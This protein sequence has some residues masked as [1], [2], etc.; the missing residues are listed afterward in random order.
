MRPRAVLLLVPLAA[1]ELLLERGQLL[2][3]GAVGQVVRAEH[4]VLGG[5]GER[6]AVRRREDVVRRQHQQPGLRLRLRGQR[7]V[8]GHLVAVEVR[9][10]RVTDERMHLDRLALHEHRLE[11]LQTEAVERRRTVEQHRVLL[12]DLLEHVPDLGDHRVDHLLGRLDVLHRLALDQPRHDERLEQLERHQLGQAALVEAQLRTGHDDR[13]AGVVHALAEQVLAEPALLALEHVRERL[14]RTVARARDGPAAAAVVEQRVDGLLQHALLVVDD[15]LGR[16]E[17]EQPLEPVVA[18]DHAAVEVVEVGRREATAVELHHRA[19]LRRDHRHGLQDHVLGLVVRV[20]EGR[21][22]LQA[23]DRTALLLA[24]GG[25]DLVLELLAL[26]LEVHL[27]EQVAHR[28]GAH[29]AA[30]VLAEPERRSEAVLELAEERLVGHHQ[31]GLHGLEQLPDL[32]HASD[33]VLDVG[34]GVGDVGLELLA[35]L[36]LHLLAL[37]VGQLLEVDVERVG[38]DQVVVVEALLVAGREVGDAALERLAQLQH[39]LLALGLVGVG[40]LLDLALELAQILLARLVV[41]PRHDRRGEVEDLL[42]LLG[43]HVEQ[44][45]DAARHA[46]EEPDVRDGRGQ[47]DVTHALAAHLRARDLDAAALADDALVADPLV[48]AAVALPVLGGTED[49]LAEEAVLLRLQRAVVDRLRLDDLA[50][51]PGSDLLRRREPDLDCVEII[52]VDHVIP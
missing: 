49:A 46:L 10:E 25:L 6:R 2:R 20:E 23:L 3:V 32:A 26:L 38:P 19:Q 44:V 51:A 7:H 52:D 37:V 43:S 5:H 21:D 22:D 27:L 36:L 18:V 28:L 34:L 33:R 47:V 40:D 35:Q 45:A 16:A 30:E 12:D 17:V 4:H 31:L 24:L 48:L 1:E 39:A 9:V 14:Q 50:G 15:D 41:H 11:R 8:H 13:T 42:E 29:A